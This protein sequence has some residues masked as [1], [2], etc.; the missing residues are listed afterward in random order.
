MSPAP[1]CPGSRSYGSG[2]CS[3]HRRS[4]RPWPRP[5][6]HG[7]RTGRRRAPERWPS[8]RPPEP[9]RPWPPPDRPPG[10]PSRRCQRSPEGP[11]G[12]LLLNPPPAGGRPASR[13]PG[14][15]PADR[16]AACTARCTGSRSMPSQPASIR[17]Y[18][19]RSA[20]SR[21]PPIAGAAARR[22]ATRPSAVP[23]SNPSSVVRMTNSNSGARERTSARTASGPCAWR[24][25]H[26]SMPPSATATNVWALNAWSSPKARIAAFC[27]AESPSNVKIT[28][29]PT[30]SP[31]ASWMPPPARRRPSAAARSAR[32]RS[33]RPSRTSPPPCRC[34]TGASP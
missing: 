6:P 34:R 23:R 28:S 14:R 33:R 11:G 16:P 2:G 12:T 7:P 4:P 3:S 27:P 29:P 9:P 22:A 30:D 13:P 26:G 25:S 32:G 10:P 18:S 21:M 20:V 17:V 24:R 1:S 8:Q 15:D 19:G 5:R 31:D